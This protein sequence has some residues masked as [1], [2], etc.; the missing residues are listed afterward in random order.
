[1]TDRQ[2]KLLRLLESQNTWITGKELSQILKVSDRTIRSDID[3]M[4]HEYDLP[5]IE[6]NIRKGY[7]LIIENVHQ[8]QKPVDA[9]IPQ[10]PKER[11][12]FILKKLLLTNQKLSIIDLLD[13]IFISEYALDND[14]KNIKE[15]IDTFEG[16]KITKSRN[17][18]YL[19][20]PEHSI[21][22]LYKQMLLE[23]TQKNF[24]KSVSS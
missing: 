18:L 12:T 15:F 10:T 19:E 3:A 23:E 7:R 16:L 11:S 13:E 6:S 22:E 1:M 2:E 17:H 20:G 21:R 5:L 4:N 9:L 8:S 24:L 14:L